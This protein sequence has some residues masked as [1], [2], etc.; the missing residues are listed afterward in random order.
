MSIY[1]F[2]FGLALVLYFGYLI[3]KNKRINSLG[4]VIAI[5]LGLLSWI[6]VILMIGVISFTNDT[7]TNG[8]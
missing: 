2:G 5:V 7:R 6:G 1:A 8:D 4:L 3:M